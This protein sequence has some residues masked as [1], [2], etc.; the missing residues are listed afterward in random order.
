M[1]TLYGLIRNAYSDRPY[2][3]K[4]LT[5]KTRELLQAHTESQLFELPDAVYELRSDTLQKIDQS[6][7]SDTVK[8]LNLQK[9]LHHTVTSECSSKPFLISIGER[10][11][12]VAEAYENRQVA[13]HDVLAEFR[14]LAEE[15]A[16][17]ARESAR[18]D[19]DD[20]TFAVYT[21]LKNV[22]EDVNPEQARA[23]DQVFV[24]FS[25]YRW[26][27]QQEKELRAMLYKTLRPTVGAGELIETTNKLLRLERV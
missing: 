23:V 8:V 27:D 16:R 7:A 5:A 4:G 22:I 19:L 18:L 17:A 20:N 14:K 2:V 25:D 11:E 6:E 24:Q 10:A 13:T 21:V 3:D 15:Y 9:A 1:A 26:N 12:A